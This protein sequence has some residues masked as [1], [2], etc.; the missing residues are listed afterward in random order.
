MN[1]LDTV[2]DD[3]MEDPAIAGSFNVGATR[4]ASLLAAASKSMAILTVAVLLASINLEVISR[5]IFN[6]PT[7]WVTEFSAYF[8]IAITFLGAAYSQLSGRNIRVTFVRDR[9]PSPIAVAMDT[10]AHWCS[11]F[12]CLILLWRTSAFVGENYTDLT[13]SWGLLRTP[14]WI[15]QTTVVLG[16]GCLLLAIFA[17]VLAA[18]G[19]K[20]R[21]PALV[22][23][24]AAALFIWSGLLTLQ[25]T[26]DLA[27][28]IDAQVTLSATLTLVLVSAFVLS[29]TRNALS[30]LLLILPLL[31]GYALLADAPLAHRSI[32]MLAA[33]LYLLIFGVPVTFTLG[34]LALLAIGIWLPP[35]TIV[36][37]GERSWEAVNTFEL[38][39][40]PMF[41]MMGS[42]LVSSGASRDMYEATRTLFGRMRGGLA[43]ASV[44]ASGIFA[45]VSGSSLATAAA[46][47]KVAGSEMTQRGYR[48]ELAF[49]VL[50]AGG[51]LGILIPPSIA[52]IVYGPLA[53]VPVTDLFLA[54]IVPGLLLM[55][56]FSLVVAVW[57]AIDPAAAPPGQAF[58]ATQKLQ[59]LLG[60][61]P[62]LLLILLVLGSIYLGV[63]TPTEAGGVGVLGAA[64]I[65]AM[66]RTLSWRGVLGSIEE[67]AVVTSF[68][69]LIAVGAAQMGFVV[70]Y[71]NMPQSLVGYINNADLSDTGIFLA[72]VAIYVLLGM[73]VEPISMMLITLPV[74]L[75]IASAAGW[76]L[77]WF[78]IVLVM[79]IEI[80]LITPPVGMILFVLSGVSDKAV[81]LS[82]IAL[83]AL[84]FVAAFLAM[85]ALFF[86]FPE[87]VTF[88]PKGI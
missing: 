53:G 75:P 37:L 60:V 65:S 32:G 70:D 80:G 9:M 83:G 43:H 68:L 36:A 49:G 85:I 48:P 86:L 45:A 15:P 7:I 44:G 14:L 30:L 46:M 12:V 64:A 2:N 54:G 10:S 56:A 33:L 59:A 39:A 41:I 27:L 28:G 82:R 20:R 21:H 72:L 11:L 73:F 76:D 19:S 67:A 16:Y 34:M 25:G 4:W 38:A 18:N 50:A 35:V 17:C 55:A 13:R 87:I 5:Y 40:I 81:D 78:G 24:P 88:L 29:G 47:G 74:V 77:L 84:P 42:L 22:L 71:L 52:M 8:V 57:V 66:R 61:G 26:T 23:L 62:F 51:T 58:S 1:G 79:L 69:L 63:A 31:L 6:S 3:I